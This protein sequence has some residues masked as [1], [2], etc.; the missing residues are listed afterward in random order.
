M[1]SSARW[2]RSDCRNPTVIADDGVP[3]CLS[4]HESSATAVA[5]LV[6]Q[7]YGKAGQIDLPVEAPLGESNFWWP[8]CVPYK[9]P[10]GE[11]SQAPRASDDGAGSSNLFRTGSAL[12]SA[13]TIYPLSLDSGHFRIICLTASN[14]TSSPIH[15]NLEQYSLD[16]CPEYETIS[17]LWG[18][19]EGDSTLCEPVYVGIFWDIVLVTK[20][21]SAVLHYLRPPRG[22]RFIWLD[23]ICI[24]QAD[25]TEKPAQISNMSEIY[26]NCQRVVAYFGSD[27][28]SEPPKRAFRQRVDFQQSAFSSGKLSDRKDH[29]ERFLKGC[30][31][32]SGLSQEQLL[33]RRYLTRVWIV[34][35]L[36]LSKK[37]LFP[38]GDS[39]V[40]CDVTFP[41][42]EGHFSLSRE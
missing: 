14:H 17:Y 32:K 1:D 23:A 38:L 19:E 4:C 12:S 40:I 21:C 8:P 41:P 22:C 13:S 20:N 9:D 24:N 33:Q 28:I 11:I 34:Q 5:Q 31:K 2:H 26:R 35:E 10:Q 37:A 25:E 7:T 29:C 42:F 15:I 27:L 18:G 6:A 36:L 16:D 39:D 30:A 3:R